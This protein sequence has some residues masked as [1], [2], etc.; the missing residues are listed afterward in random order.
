MPTTHSESGEVSPP[1]YESLSPPSL[2]RGI[3]FKLARMAVI[4]AF[5]LGLILSSLQ[6]LFDYKGEVDKLNTVVDEIIRVAAAPAQRAAFEL[7]TEL[8]GEVVSS[9]LEYEFVASASISEESLG[10]LAEK[11][12]AEPT[13]EVVPGFARLADRQAMFSVPLYGLDAATTSNSEPLGKLQVVVDQAVGLS[14]FYQRSI[15]VIGS[16]V[17]RSLVLAILL[18]IVFHFVIGRALINLSTRLSQVDPGSAEKAIVPIDPPHKDDEIGL[19]TKSVNTLL[20]TIDARTRKLESSESALL[21]SE[22]RFKEFAEAASDW[23]WETDRENKLTFISE[24][25]FALTEKQSSRVLGRPPSNVQNPEAGETGW[26]SLV[27]LIQSLEAFRDC[28]C[29]VRS[30]KGELC[31]LSINGKP[32]YGDAGEFV[33]FRG[34]ATDITRQA[35]AEAQL[36]QAL[37]MQAV[38]QLTGGVSHDFNNLLLVIL[39][40]LELARADEID[41]EARFNHIDKASLA[42]ER[43]AELT[44]RLLAFSRKQPLAP[45]TVDANSLL[46]GMDNMFRRTL[47]EDIEIE[48]ITA[49]GLWHCEADPPQLESALLNLAINARDAMPEG[50]KLTVET[51]NVHFDDAYAARDPELQPGQYVQIAVTDTGHGIPKEMLGQI[52]EPFFTTKKIGRGSGLGLSM[53]Y[54][55][56]KQSGGQLN[57]YSEVGEGTTVKLYLPRSLASSADRPDDILEE[58]AEPDELTRI[59]VVE[60]EPEVL[61]LVV[62][63]LEGVGYQVSTARNGEE[64]LEVIDSGLHPD[65]LLTDAVLPGGYNGAALSREIQ[66]RLPSM[67]VLY[68]SGYTENAIVHG[69]RLDPGVLL[70]QK[71]FRRKD[72]LRKIYQALESE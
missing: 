40:N 35:D 48:L 67:K 16:G 39:G 21:Q 55:F 29:T 4:T 70:L 9:L 32:R 58:V 41:K 65:L 1:A 26:D 7:N 69:G 54:G 8:A 23:F 34:T 18:L 45:K 31:L 61:S 47:G 14:P 49:A 22:S 53:V 38:G 5:L 15:F 11:I 10:L 52:F 12:R 57:V 56:A 66:D 72:L 17:V 42:A 71:P 3:S 63:I 60:D 33:G 13:A 24:Q 51:G 30:K 25:F 62:A 44:Q 36:R 20:G 28:R 6:L 59:L 43:G 2:T 37:K 27:E 50:G 19:V 46:R 68:M 64:A